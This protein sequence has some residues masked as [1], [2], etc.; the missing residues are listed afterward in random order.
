[1]LPTYCQHVSKW[2]AVTC[3]PGTPANSFCVVL[4]TCQLTC[5]RHVGLTDTCLLFW[6]SFWHANIRLCQLRGTAVWLI[7]VIFA[8]QNVLKELKLLTILGWMAL[9][10]IHALY[11][12]AYMPYRL[13]TQRP[14]LPMLWLA[15]VKLVHPANATLVKRR[16]T[17]VSKPL[18]GC[19][20]AAMRWQFALGSSAIVLL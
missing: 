3:W 4:L 15:I 9:H 7:R 11:S 20:L 2:H 8:A 17:S 14:M 19:Q 12:L 18:V 6:P 16:R 10:A 1:M 5:L 13:I